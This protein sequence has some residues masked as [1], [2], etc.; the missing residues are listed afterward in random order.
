LNLNITGGF[1]G[2]LY[3]YL[4]GP[5]GQFA[6]LLN[7]VG[8]TGSNPFGYSDAGMNITLEELAVNNIHDYA[9]ASLNG[10]TWEADGRNV[11]PQSAGGTLYGTSSAANLSLFQNT[12]ADGES[13]LFIADLSPGG[14]TA[15]LNST[16]L[17]IETVPEPQ[18]WP[19]LVGGL[20]LLWLRWGRLASSR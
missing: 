19:L 17:T 3:A 16:R 4:T 5:Q 12:A 8:V 9:N 7:R 11:D 20:A 6:V 13:T 1:N 15:D 18:A 10:T 14:G 2:D